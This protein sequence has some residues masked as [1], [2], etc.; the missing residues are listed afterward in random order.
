MKVIEAMDVKAT[1]LRD[2]W[3]VTMSIRVRAGSTKANAAWLAGQLTGAVL[4]NGFS[5]PMEITTN[6][7]EES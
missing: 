7:E 5:P 1:Q 6:F 4:S 2:N 3:V